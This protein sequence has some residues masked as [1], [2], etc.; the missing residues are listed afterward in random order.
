MTILLIRGYYTTT[1]LP[2]GS[3]LGTMYYIVLFSAIVIFPAWWIVGYKRQPFSE[4]GI[5]THYWKES[6]L[7]S[8]AITAVFTWQVMTGY[9]AIY[10]TELIP[11]LLENGL[12]LWEPFFVFCW[13]QLRYECAF[14]ILPVIL[15]AGLCFAAYHVGTSPAPMLVWLAFYDMA[16]AALFRRTTSLLVLWPLA[17]SASAAKGTLAGGMLFSWH[18][19]WTCLD[20]LLIQLGF[21]IYL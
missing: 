11:H 4:L 6:L 14:G 21:L 7:L 15:L 17:W 10:G 16:F 1:H 20:I 9:S 8:I 13:L 2:P 5:T 3:L 19:V 18:D 12:I